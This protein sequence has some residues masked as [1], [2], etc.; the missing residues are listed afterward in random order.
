MNKVKQI[1][2]ACVARHWPALLLFGI[3]LV[4]GLYYMHGRGLSMTSDPKAN[5]WNFFWQTLPMDA[6][7]KDLWGSLWNLHAQPPLFNL[8]GFLIHRIVGPTHHLVAQHYV[9]IL[10]GSAMCGMFYPLLKHMIRRPVVAFIAALV[11]SLNP[12]I[13]LYE[14]FILY[15]LLTAF[16]VVAALFMLMRYCETTK[17]SRLVLFV[18]LINALAL[19]RSAY[20]MIL[21]IPILVLGGILAARQWRRF[22]IL[23]LLVCLPTLGWY[24]KNQVKFG[25]FGASSWM[26]SNMWR[27]VSADYS[28]DELR[29]FH[30]QG[31]VEFDAVARKYFDPPSSFR[32]LGYNKTSDVDVLSRDDYNNINMI[33]I[34][35]MHLRNAKRLKK[36]DP[37]HYHANV[38]Q[39][40]RFLCKPSNE[41]RPLTINTHRIMPHVHVASYLNGRK[42]ASFLNE[43]FNTRFKSFY[44]ALIP[45]PLVVL[46]IRAVIRARLSWQSWIDTIRANAVAI[47]MAG[48]VF[49]VTAISC[50]FEYGENCRFKFSIEAVILMLTVTMCF[51]L[52]KPDSV[53]GDAPD[54]ISTPG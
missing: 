45:L 21:L 20:H 4:L 24:A 5:S 23:S 26:G 17:L 32:D 9:Q 1:I 41:T 12:V 10:L 54:V 22:L 36:H 51:P 37:K 29:T 43:R 49:Y 50:L 47:T 28:K 46:L 42:L 52:R 18:L 30:K 40:Y 11:I 14:A 7:Q 6:M 16:L 38:A 13:F 48:L 53:A 27:S 3:H 25:F 33:D 39:A 8:Y 19:T 15:T 2:T 44:M 31:V 34:S 35:M